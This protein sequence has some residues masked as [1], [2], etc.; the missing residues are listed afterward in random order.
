MAASKKKLGSLSHGRPR[1]VAKPPPSLSSRATRTLIR[2]HHRLHKA[3]SAALARHDSST[4][5]KLEAAIEEQGGL[6]SYQIAS[7]TGQSASRGGDS[8]KL[9]VSWLQGDGGV[10]AKKLRLLEVGALST[11]NACS[12]CGLF[13]VTRIDLHSQ[14]PGIETQDFMERPL[15]RD[16]AE[17]FDVI[18]LSLVLNYVPEALGR[19]EMLKRTCRFLLQRHEGA[20]HETKVV[21]QDRYP[22]LFIV[23]PAPCV[24][25]SRYMNQERLMEIMEDLGYKRKQEKVSSKL[26]YSLWFWTGSNETPKPFP[27][28]E[29]NPGKA[30]NNFAITII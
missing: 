10:T 24:T 6:Q 22:A 11:A 30:R 18:S 1:A 15:P 2:T 23:L 25:N 28:V 5:A 3:R 9:L 7:I 12:T 8:S 14:A 27:K 19:G 29:V 16:D 20:E 4:V 13:D 26:A 17:R 21:Q